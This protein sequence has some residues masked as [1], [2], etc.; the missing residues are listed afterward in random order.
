MRS[1]PASLLAQKP[2]GVRRTENVGRGM[3]V[4]C[5]TWLI[6][7]PWVDR[8]ARIALI[9]ADTGFGPMGRGTGG[10]ERVLIQSR[11]QGASTRENMVAYLFGASAPS[12]GRPRRVPTSAG[13][14]GAREGDHEGRAGLGGMW[15]SL[16]RAWR[17]VAGR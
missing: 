6:R 15:P 14:A 4:R 12:G 16:L 11:V 10:K 9:A 8:A 5:G 13:R 17:A 2:V 3:A 7:G 1:Q